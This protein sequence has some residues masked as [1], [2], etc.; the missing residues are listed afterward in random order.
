MDLPWVIIH[1]FIY[2]VN[3][4][5]ENHYIQAV[6]VFLLTNYTISPKKISKINDLTNYLRA[7]HLQT[8][9]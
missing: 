7:M 8:P 2:I 5:F 1:Y 3:S 9:S 6:A 4:I